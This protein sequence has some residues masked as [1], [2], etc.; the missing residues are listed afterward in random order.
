MVKAQVNIQDTFLNQLRKDNIPVTVYLINGFQLRGFVR[1]FDNFTVVIESEGKPQLVYKHAI[2]TFA[3]AR[4]VNYQ[5]AF[6]ERAREERP[7]AAPTSQGESA[8]P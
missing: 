2:S 8:S 3:P 7:E 4:P 1:A 6:A 5:G